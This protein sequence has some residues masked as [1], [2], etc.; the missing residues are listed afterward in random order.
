MRLVSRLSTLGLALCL[1]FSLSYADNLKSSTIQLGSI[2]I[3]P[4]QSGQ[5]S[6]EK[7]QDQVVYNVTCTIADATNNQNRPIIGFHV[8]SC[9]GANNNFIFNNRDLGFMCAGNHQ[10]TLDPNPNNTLQARNVF[11]W[12]T[13]LSF[14]NTDDTDTIAINNC[15]ANP[16]V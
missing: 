13:T 6:L 9:S 11:D 1:S 15:V 10:V 12:N 4:E 8:E 5:I 14:I 2:Q 7:L 3:K 16:I